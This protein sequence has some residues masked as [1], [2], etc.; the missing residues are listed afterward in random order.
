MIAHFRNF[1]A[2]SI[3]L[4][5]PDEISSVDLP[6]EEFDM[7]LNAAATPDLILRLILASINL[8][9]DYAP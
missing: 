4:I 7:P 2:W 3:G 1:R 9:E 8:K 6:R 5:H